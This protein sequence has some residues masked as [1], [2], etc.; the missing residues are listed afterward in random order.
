MGFGDRQWHSK[1]AMRKSAPEIG[2]DIWHSHAQPY[3][4]RKWHNLKYTTR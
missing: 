4:I 3:G 1:G 2:C